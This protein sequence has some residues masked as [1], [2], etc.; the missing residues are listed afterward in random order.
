MNGLP[1]TVLQFGSGKFLRAF[2]DLFIHQANTAGQAVGRVVIVQS[3]G[4]GRADLLNQ[5]QGR[6]HV[7]VRGLA[8]G[9]TVD[10][11]EESASV[12]RALSAASQWTD[13]LAVA[14]SPALRFIISNTA[15]VGY[16]LDPTDGPHSNPPS[17]YPARLLLLLR[18]RHRAGQPGVTILPCE[19]FLH[20]ADRLCGIVTDLAAA[21]HMPVDFRTWLGS[22]CQWRNTLVD[23]IVTVAPPGQPL[24]N[25]DPLT[26]VAEPYALWAIEVKQGPNNI[27]EHPAITVTPNAEP[28]FLRK[29][30][31]LNAAHTALLSQAL[32]RGF[33]FVRQSVSDPDIADWLNRLL[34]D[35]IVPV[36]EGRVDD[37]V[38]FARSVLE[39]F[40]NPFLEHKLRDIAAYHEAKV[41][42]RL[43]PTIDEFR[44]KFGRVP[45][46]L[47]AASKWRLKE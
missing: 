12:S 37:P 10:R 18:E 46:L 24:L 11:V 15:E 34:F 22:A 16:N 14:R 13:V 39:R 45:P 4:A 7:L 40:H 44:E 30:R 23:R 2:A 35:E 29:V 25:D 27:F 38:G 21:W 20:N 43:L 28:Y 42:I 26:T 41:K 36:L 17:S 47:E 31:I 33:Q 9:Q 5:Q 8:N 19:L 6:Y 1:E 32:P 3:T